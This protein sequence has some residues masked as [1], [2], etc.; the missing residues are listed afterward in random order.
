MFSLYLFGFLWF[1]ISL[2]LRIKA[3]DIFQCVFDESGTFKTLTKYEPSDP[4]LL[5]KCFSLYKKPDIFYKQM[6][7]VQKGKPKLVKFENICTYIL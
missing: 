2:K 7:F 4:Y 5:Q 6:F 1:I 3:R